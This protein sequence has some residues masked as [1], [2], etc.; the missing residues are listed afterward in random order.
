MFLEEAITTLYGELTEQYRAPF[1]GVPEHAKQV[2]GLAHT[3]GALQGW[4]RSRNWH[5][6]VTRG[7][8]L[9]ALFSLAQFSPH[10]NVRQQFRDVRAE[11]AALAAQA[12]EWNILSTDYDPPYFGWNR[13][14]QS[15]D[16]EEMLYIIA[17]HLTLPLKD[18]PP[19][20][21]PRTPAPDA[22]RRRKA[23]PTVQPS[24]E[25]KTP[26]GK[27]ITVEFGIDTGS[28]RNIRQKLPKQDLLNQ[29]WGL[30][31]GKYLYVDKVDEQE[32]GYVLAEKLLSLL[33]DPYSTFFRPSSARSFQ[34]QLE[35][36]LSG[37]GAQVEK[38]AEGGVVVVSP[39]ANSPALVAG[40]KPGDRITHVNGESVLE[41]D[42]HAAVEKIRGPVGTLVELTVVRS[43]ATLSFK[44]V[45]AKITIP[46]VEVSMQENVAVIHLFQ[47]G[48]RTIRELGAILE[49]ALAKKPDGLVLD[50]RNN[51]G[52][53][54][55]AAISVLEHFFPRGT[56]VAK[57][58]TRLDVRDEVVRGAQIVPEDLPLVVM[59]NGGSASASE[60]VA[61]ALQDL[62]RALVI[63]VK[64]FGK[65]SVQ[66]VVQFESGESAKLTTGEW[67]TPHGRSIEKLGIKPDVAL[68]EA[69]P[70]S[71]DEWLLEAIRIIQAK[72]RGGR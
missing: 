23:T 30:V 54:L 28:R 70:G 33:N 1:A 59:V 66:E 12:V 15:Q 29:L 17:K 58:K 21:R 68:E 60:I 48:E 62:D 51:P 32:A 5:L 71:R 44:I 3:L 50:L 56:V 25:R 18:P 63:G 8:A 64:T 39:L 14:L 9:R 67:F 41:L 7:Q 11:D 72:A 10:P 31:Q 45:R 35:G 65:G 4:E 2:V 38:S 16:L 47:F 13:A 26:S 69:S 27:K 46:E 34:Q 6:P 19:L 24:R 57:I 52:G 36:E 49:K 55:D 42:L 37:I 61:G 53:L 40:L 20:V 22:A 43:G